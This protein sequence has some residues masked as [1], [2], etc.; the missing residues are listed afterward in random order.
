ML[1]VSSASCR[2]FFVIYD[3]LLLDLFLL[4]IAL[5]HLLDATTL[6]SRRQWRVLAPFKALHTRGT[7]SQPPYAAR[8]SQPSYTENRD[9][10]RKPREVERESHRKH[11]DR[12][13]EGRVRLREE[14]KHTSRP[15]RSTHIPMRIEPVHPTR[16]RTLVLTPS[17]HRRRS[18][19][20][21]PLYQ[22]Q[23]YEWRDHDRE[24][25]QNTKR[26]REWEVD[27]REHK[28]QQL[29]QRTGHSRTL[30][31]KRKV[32]SSSSTQ[33]RKLAPQAQAQPRMI[34]PGPNAR[35][36]LPSRKPKL[37]TTIS[38]TSKPKPQNPRHPCPHCPQS[39]SRKNDAYRH[40][41]R[42]H[43][44]GE[45][46]VCVCGRELNRSDALMRHWRSCKFGKGMEAKVEGEIMGDNEAGEDEGD[47]V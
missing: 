5:K 21:V 18:T 11:D 13:M 12:V 33:H 15:T 2:R 30:A 9:F 4:E 46:F 39:F 31:K 35:K 6:L 37:P 32:P 41:A 10:Q 29:K 25:F 23:E 38:L 1:A 3:K 14:G 8:R 40:I 24:R 42:R 19:S 22:K 36:P 44:E 43:E 28:Q 20:P 7:V 27:E 34:L 17:T 47:E 26:K 45:V 16:P